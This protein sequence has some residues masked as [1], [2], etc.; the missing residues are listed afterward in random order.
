MA[1]NDYDNL[2]DFIGT[3]DKKYP[4]LIIPLLTNNKNRL[5]ILKSIL[6]RLKSN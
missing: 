5:K 4:W 6:K 2:I 1:K 3:L